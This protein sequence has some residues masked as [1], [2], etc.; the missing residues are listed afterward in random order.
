[1]RY[2]GQIYR[3]FSEAN[4]YLL[5]CTVGCSHNGCTFCGMYKDRRF[6]VRSTDEIL[7]DIR[8]AGNHY[9]D[10]EKVFLCDGD[11]VCME[12]ETLLAILKALYDTFA[13]LRHVGTYVGPQSTLEKSMADLARL[14]GAGLTKAYLGV[15]SGDDAV[16]TDI[17]KGVTAAQML[18]AGRRLVEAGFNLSSMV[19]LGI[20]GTGEPARRHA[21]LTADITNRMKPRYLAALTYT[22]VPHTALFKKVESGKF[23]LP[24]P[25]ETLEEMKVMFENITIDNLT[26]VGAHAS[27]YLPVSGKLQKDKAAML[28]TV[29]A[30]LTSRNMNALRP[31]AMRGL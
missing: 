18:E 16:L 1:M 31:D 27:N 4:S 23:V 17:N 8:M 12:T 15:E 30:V 20:A 6:R 7:E 13:S 9:G 19:L 29:N 11:A 2:E 22:P 26:F 28:Q 3:P 25:F 14:R 24:D 5:Q 21:A 10:V